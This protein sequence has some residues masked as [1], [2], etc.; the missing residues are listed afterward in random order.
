MKKTLKS[1]KGF[2]MVEIIIVLV[3]IAILIGAAVPAM[4]GF[5]NEARGKAEATIARSCWTAVQSVLSEEFALADGGAPTNQG[6]I[7]G[8]YGAAGGRLDRMLAPDAD[9]NSILNISYTDAG[10]LEYLIYQSGNGAGN[11]WVL[12]QAGLAAEVSRNTAL[13]IAD[14]TMTIPGTSIQ[15]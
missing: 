9:S 11:T 7:L 2:T 12:I 5:V 4:I 13:T 10:Q 15:E 3:I 8:V 6:N 14:V 1:K